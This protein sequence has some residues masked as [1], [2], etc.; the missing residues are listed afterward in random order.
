MFI[1]AHFIVARTWKPPVSIDRG[2]DKEDMVHLS[3][4]IL[5][6]H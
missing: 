5:L 6:G 3:N 2:M 4:G 1:A